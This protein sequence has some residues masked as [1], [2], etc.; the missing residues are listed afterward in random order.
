MTRTLTCSVLSFSIIGFLEA[1]ALSL[2][3]DIQSTEQ[4]LQPVNLGSVVQNKPQLCSGGTPLLNMVNKRQKTTDCVGIDCG[5][6]DYGFHES[7]TTDDQLVKSNNIF[8]NQEESVDV[9]VDL[10]AESR[11]NLFG[12]EN[13]DWEDFPLNDATTNIFLS[14]SNEQDTPHQM[15]ASIS[16]IRT[17]GTGNGAFEIAA[18]RNPALTFEQ[19]PITGFV[20]T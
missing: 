16:D 17:D 5:A 14:S 7:P 15:E 9:P 13:N 2:P 8:G 1:Y 18:N 19:D 10:D 12:E 3:L 11:E 20:L 4:D 6:N